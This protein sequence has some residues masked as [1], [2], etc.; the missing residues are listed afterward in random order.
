[1]SEEA[2]A[3]GKQ[4][5]SDIEDENETT[6]E[7]SMTLSS[8]KGLTDFSGFLTPLQ[9]RQLK[10]FFT[11]ASKNNSGTVTMSQLLRQLRHNKEAQFI[12]GVDNVSMKGQTNFNKIFSEMDSSQ[13]REITF[14]QFLNFIY[15]RWKRAQDSLLEKTKNVVPLSVSTAISHRVIANNLDAT[16]L[17]EIEG[18]EK[19]TATGVLLSDGYVITSS[20]VIPTFETAQKAKVVFFHEADADG[21]EIKARPELLYHFWKGVTVQGEE[22][23]YVAIAIDLHTLVSELDKIPDRSQNCPPLTESQRN[24]P[25]LRAAIM[26][27]VV[28]ANVNKIT[29]PVTAEEK[30]PLVLIQ[31][32]QDTTTKTYHTAMVSRS[33]KSVVMYNVHRTAESQ[34]QKLRTTPG[35]PVF[36]IDG[37]LMALHSHSPVGFG[38]TQELVDGVAGLPTSPKPEAHKAAK[39]VNWG[40]S[41]QNIVAD[42]RHTIHQCKVQARRH[43]VAG[44]ALHSRRLY[45]KALALDPTAVCPF[46]LRACEFM[47]VGDTKLRNA[48]V[49]AGVPNARPWDREPFQENLDLL[50]CNEPDATKAQSFSGGSLDLG[51]ENPWM[52][53]AK[54]DIPEPAAK[55]SAEAKAKGV[56]EAGSPEDRKRYDALTHKLA[57]SKA[58]EIASAGME[59]D[60]ARAEPYLIRACAQ[61]RLGNIEE[62]LDD[63]TT[64]INLEAK[65][66]NEGSDERMADALCYRGV[67]QSR[68]GDVKSG[69][70]DF[71]KAIEL[72]DQ[73]PGYFYCRG[74]AF[75]VT[76]EQRQ[77]SVLDDI[78]SKDLSASADLSHAVK[79]YTSAI[80]LA[81]KLVYAYYNRAR[82]LASMNKLPSA[83]KDYNTALR[84]DPMHSA[85]FYNRG[86]CYAKKVRSDWIR[87]HDICEQSEYA[88]KIREVNMLLSYPDNLVTPRRT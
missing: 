88:S 21:V 26:M 20:S 43:L 33:T 15:Q 85:A 11:K 40:L 60:P 54:H 30:M 78:P 79:D 83:I 56:A 14:K 52:L 24:M 77:R 69:I 39:A 7:L 72:T 87:A 57:F 63:L 67:L 75:L 76:E 44:R 84:L 70:E 17:I 62:A 19:T 80:A 2:N 61:E 22:L 45:R 49:N 42:L 66:N 27:G 12:F 59:L 51:M 25:I 73:V 37:T 68:V 47:L 48:R 16:C 5:L 65:A 6:S 86:V 1:M 46:V 10:N 50:C 82:S 53:L 71:T 38:L 4:R 32:E 31:H 23:G 35:S 8:S 9:L 3:D 29:A 58:V 13:S 64:M 81:D 41:C 74:N 34:E 28:A 36:A 55:T 18:E